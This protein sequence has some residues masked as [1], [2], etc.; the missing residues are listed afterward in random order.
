[1]SFDRDM[2]HG[3]NYY[4]NMRRV[5]DARATKKSD[6]LKRRKILAHRDKQNYQLEY[7]RI[8]DLMHSKTIRRDTKYMLEHRIKNLEELGAKAVNNITWYCCC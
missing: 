8:R 1:M 2:K 6:V 4:E 7:D 3:L 5:L